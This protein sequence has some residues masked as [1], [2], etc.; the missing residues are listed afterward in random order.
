MAGDKVSIPQLCGENWPT[1]K[2]KFCGLLAYKGGLCAL[3]KPESVEGKK[4]SSQARE[5]ILIHMEDAYVK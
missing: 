5:L 4:V 3:E 1:W 2:A